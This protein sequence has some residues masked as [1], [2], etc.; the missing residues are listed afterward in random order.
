MAVS[1]A[2]RSRLSRRSFLAVSAAGLASVVTGCTS[3]D[4][5]AG[6]PV[7]AAQVDALATQVA[8]QE[9]LVAAFAAATSAGG[10]GPE[11]A[12][13]AEQA[14]LQLERI[15]AASPGSEASGSAGSATPPAVGADVRGWLR[16]QVTATADSHAAAC[17]EQTGARAALLGSIAAGLRGSAARL[18]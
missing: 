8:A 7:T 12:V 10:L 2:A 16:Q 5:D 13:L 6:E 9:A 14:G 15:R 3:G 1:P 18:A 4:G 17:Q 11:V